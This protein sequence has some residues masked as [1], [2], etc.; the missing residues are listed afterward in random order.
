HNRKDSRLGPRIPRRA[1]RILDKLHWE[2]MV[3][4]S[5]KTLNPVVGSTIAVRAYATPIDDSAIRPSADRRDALGSSE[6]SLILD[7]ETSDDPGQNLRFGTYQVRRK[8]EL[9]DAGIFYNPQT[10]SESGVKLIEDYGLENHLTVVTVE[11]FI[12]DV[13]FYYAYDLGALCIGFNLPFDLS[14][15]ALSHSPARGR[16]RGGFSFK[17]SE[18]KERPRVRVKHLNHFTSLIDFSAPAE[19]YTPRSERNRGDRVPPNRGY[20]VDCHALAGALY[21]RSFTLKSLAEYLKT[22]HQKLETDEYGGPIT[23]RFLEYAVNDVRVTWDCFAKMKARYDQY[24]LT[25]T[26]INKIFS[27][28]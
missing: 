18:N 24:G 21:S 14:R 25:K 7:T 8:G 16:M 26:P 3:G 4:K 20:F 6:W 13:F 1:G 15:L 5:M 2:R 17:L 23:S 11:R 22:E 28:A 10:I 12:E 27:E 9:Q 19:E